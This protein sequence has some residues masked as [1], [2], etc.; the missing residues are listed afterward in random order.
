MNSWFYFFIHGSCCC[1]KL[2]SVSETKKCH[3]DP[4]EEG[5][6]ALKH[7]GKNGKMLKVSWPE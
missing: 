2:K 1:N 5:K 6:T 7:T 3:S 4:V